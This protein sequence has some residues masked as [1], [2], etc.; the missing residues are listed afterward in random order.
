MVLHQITEAIFFAQGCWF[1]NPNVNDDARVWVPRVTE[2]QLRGVDC[3][4]RCR[5]LCQKLTEL[6]FTYDELRQGNATEARTP[7]VTMLDANRMYT[8]RG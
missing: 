3:Q 4:L 2:A 5:D 6:L 1:G 7:G 8:I